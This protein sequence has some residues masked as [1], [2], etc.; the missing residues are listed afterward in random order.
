MCKLHS[1]YK[2]NI[3]L[4]DNQIVN[5]DLSDTLKTQ[6]TGLLANIDTCSMT[7]KFVAIN[8]FLC[9]AQALRDV[10]LLDKSILNNWYDILNV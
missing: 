7:D 8:S 4:V 9:Y 1:D 3:A 2:D 10:D 5:S 6:L